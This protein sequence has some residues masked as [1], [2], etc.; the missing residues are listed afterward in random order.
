MSRRRGWK[1]LAYALLRA[2][3]DANAVR[4]GKISRRIGRRLYGKATGRIA[5]R[6]FR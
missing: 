6:I 4:R 2:H 3:G 1:S 5:A